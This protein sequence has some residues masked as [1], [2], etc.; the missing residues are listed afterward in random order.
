MPRRLINLPRVYPV[1]RG[2]YSLSITY[3]APGLSGVYA[4]Y[5]PSHAFDTP[6]HHSICI[7]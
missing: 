4:I 2:R 1:I 6:T 3:T 5:T 7:T